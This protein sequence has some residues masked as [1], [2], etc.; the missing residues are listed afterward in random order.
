MDYRKLGF[1]LNQFRILPAWGIV[2]CSRNRAVIMQDLQR[3]KELDR[4]PKGDYTAMGY[5]LVLKKEYRN[6]VIYRLKQKSRMAALVFGVLF[7]PMDTLFINAPQIGPGLYIQHGFATIISARS[8]GSN[9]YINQQV[10][11][12]FEG[13]K[14]PVIGNDV[15]ICAGAKVIGNAV[16]GDGSV[17]G[18]NAV[19]T[20]EVPPGEV[21]GGVPAVFIKK[22]ENP[23]A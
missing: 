6:L 21:W 9:C 18:A 10:T 5:L 12:G 22:V 8:I 20:K 1:L 2:C 3:W 7:R 15:R 14:L 11:I 23:I 19:V 4:L 13:E 17:I 16:I